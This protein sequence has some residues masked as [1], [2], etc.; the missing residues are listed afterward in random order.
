[1]SILGKISGTPFICKIY[2]DYIGNLMPVNT[3]EKQNFTD[4]SGNQFTW[5][6][7]YF[8]KK[9][10]RF[11]ETEK[12]TKAGSVYTQKLQITFPN[13]DDLRSDRITKIKEAKFVRI[14]LS[15]GNSFAMGRNDFFQ[16]KKLEITQ[17][18]DALKTTITFKCLT[19]FSAGNLQITDISNIIEFLMPE[20][21]PANLIHV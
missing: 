15:N 8:A 18:S 2:L 19:M 11:S 6:P 10:V 1:M 4:S 16:N 17:K 13:Y 14:E 7:V 3:A 12:S 20:E 5:K 9:R 21:N